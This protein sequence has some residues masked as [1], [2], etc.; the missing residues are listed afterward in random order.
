M[1]SKACA[2]YQHGDSHTGTVIHEHDGY[3]PMT[4]T[5]TDRAL[6]QK[7]FIIQAESKITVLIIREKKAPCGN[8]EKSPRVND[9][10][11]I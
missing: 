11:I 10:H 4:V 7:S 2:D 9:V 8:A 5:K 1:L 3:R 6:K